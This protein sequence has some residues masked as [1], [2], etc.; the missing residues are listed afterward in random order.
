MDQ[1]KY[2]RIIIKVGT[3]TI[4]YPNGRLN[5]RLIEKLAW[6][7][8]DFRNRGLDVALVTS[9]A[10]GVGSVRLG[11]ESRPQLTRQKQAAAAV[12]QAALIQ[13]YQNFF[14]VYHHS[15]AQILLT[16]DDFRGERLQ[17]TVNT[18]ETLF[19]LGVIP[20]INANDV[21]STLEIEGAAFSDND[22]LSA[23]VAAAIQADLLVLLTD[24]D[25]FYDKNPRTH[26]DAKRIPL[27]QEVTDAVMAMAGD[28]GSRFSVG[29][30][31]T[32][33]KAAAVCL[34]AGVDMVIAEGS[35]PAVLNRI[36]DGED[37]GTRFSRR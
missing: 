12:G 27:V 8:S 35:D 22:Q 37:I 15:V 24:I 16:R 17:N 13:I 7:L 14:N 29:G 23:S 18:F 20:I 3:S 28:H 4:T 19:E 36:L 30:M 31:G 5:L 26:A 2:Q 10:I 34:D 11:F 33:L 6:E 9:G 21:T 1:N 25:A 32:K